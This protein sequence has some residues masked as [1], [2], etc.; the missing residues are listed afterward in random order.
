MCRYQL[1]QVTISQ[2]GTVM[3]TKFLT[4]KVTYTMFLFIRILVW[5]NTTD[6]FK[7]GKP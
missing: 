3:F 6:N 7:L 2:G 1:D 5:R 4:L